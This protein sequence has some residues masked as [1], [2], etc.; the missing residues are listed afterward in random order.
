MKSVLV[1]KCMHSYLEVFSGRKLP[2]KSSRKTEVSGKMGIG[3]NIR[4]FYAG[5]FRKFA[6]NFRKFP[7]SYSYSV[8]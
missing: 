3:L 6:G 5:N 7:H 8:V 4:K 2:I 1:S